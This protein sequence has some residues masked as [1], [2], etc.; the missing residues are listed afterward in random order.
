MGPSTAALSTALLC[1]AVALQGLGVL[2][3]VN[4]L[5][6]SCVC[7]KIVSKTWTL[8]EQKDSW[9]TSAGRTVPSLRGCCLSQTLGSNQRKNPWQSYWQ[10]LARPEN[11]DRALIRCWAPTGLPVIMVVGHEVVVC[12]FAVESAENVGLVERS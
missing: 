5:L 2:G 7:Q 8:S 12:F 3:F 6:L 11:I 9:L 4:R 10:L 1:L